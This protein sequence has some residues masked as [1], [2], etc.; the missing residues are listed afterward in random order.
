MSDKDFN[1][2]CEL[3]ALYRIL[4]MYG[5]TDLANQCAGVVQ[6]KIK[7]TLLFILMECFM[8]K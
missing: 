4:R 8:R 5:M 6:L 7:I 2:R 3:A 1:A